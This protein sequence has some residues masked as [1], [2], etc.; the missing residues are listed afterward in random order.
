MIACCCPAPGYNSE[1]MVTPTG[2]NIRATS[3]K[4]EDR[5]KNL[6]I[7]IGRSPGNLPT[8]SQASH[9]IWYW[10]CVSISKVLFQTCPWPVL[11]HHSLSVPQLFCSL[12]SLSSSNQT[13]IL[14][15]LAGKKGKVFHLTATTESQ[16]AIQHLPL[17]HFKGATGTSTDAAATTCSKHF[18]VWTWILNKP[19]KALTINLHFTF[20]WASSTC[21]FWQQQRGLCTS[22]F[23]CFPQ[24][25]SQLC[26]RLREFYFLF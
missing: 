19:Y 14:E 15:A 5:E 8:L 13:T 24:L 3:H 9:S 16:Q 17:T 12:H 26:F 23:S 4:L 2:R 7:R 10:K 20:S 21:M 1:Y 11:P 18:T 22:Y 6:P 25:A